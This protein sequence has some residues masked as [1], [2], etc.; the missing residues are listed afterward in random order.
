[1][2]AWTRVTGDWKVAQS[3][4]AGLESL[5]YVRF[6]QNCSSRREEALIS[7]RSEPRYLGCYGVLKMAHVAWTFL[8]AS[9]GDFPVPSLRTVP[10]CA[11][12]GALAGINLDEPF[13]V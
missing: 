5:R 3:R 12:C 2:N 1:M 6:F 13:V 4:I 7:M 10:G 8:S 11:L 9:S